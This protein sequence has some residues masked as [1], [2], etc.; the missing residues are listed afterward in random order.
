MIRSYTL[1][2]YPNYSVILV[3][4]ASSGELV[5]RYYSE[6]ERIPNLRIT[7]FDTVFNYSAAIN[8]GVRASNS[9]LVLLLNNDMKVTD[10]DWLHE[11][12][13]WALEPG[14]GIVGAKLIH[15]D[16]SLQHAGVVVGFNA[17]MGH[18]YLDAPEHY[19]GLAGS[20]DWYRNTSAVTG[21][22]QMMRRSLFEELGGYDEKYQLVFS[23]V[24]FCFR[25]IQK[26]YRILYDPFVTLFHYEGGSRGYRTPLR[27]IARAYELWEDWLLQPDP[28]YSPCLTATTIPRCLG[29]DKERELEIE[30]IRIKKEAIQKWITSSKEFPDPPA[31]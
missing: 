22:C 16:R 7:H 8:A 24:D 21:A 5:S 4:N 6:L 20:S 2:N 31:K 27:D 18:L 30:K 11:M 9:E 23:D 28:Y 17:F 25:A 12:A 19:Y 15:T 26:G 14:I 1:T 3:D 10:P 29:D 13:Q